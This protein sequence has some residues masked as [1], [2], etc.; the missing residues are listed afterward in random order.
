MEAPGVN[1]M[2]F[3]NYKKI[4]KLSEDSFCNNS[5]RAGVNTVSGVAKRKFYSGGDARS[6]R[7]AFSLSASSMSDIKKQTF[8]PCDRILST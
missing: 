7:F 2:G 6:F 3:I 1:A 4:I 8:K 5:K